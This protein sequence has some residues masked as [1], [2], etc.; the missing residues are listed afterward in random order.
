LV[1]RAFTVYQYFAEPEPL[2]IGQR[3][4]SVKVQGHEVLK[5][6]DIVREAHGADHG[7]VRQFTGIRAGNDP[8]LE[9]VPATALPPLICG[10]KLVEESGEQAAPGPSTTWQARAHRAK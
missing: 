3:V 4:F 7:I 8:H 5:D 10:V 2:T 1:Q 9:F 6:F